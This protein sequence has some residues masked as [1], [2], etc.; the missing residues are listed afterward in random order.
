M[1]GTEKCVRVNISYQ[2][3]GAASL[4]LVSVALMTYA[5]LQPMAHQARGWAI[6]IAGAAAAWT[7]IIG[8]RSVVWTVA[9]TVLRK[10]GRMLE[11]RAPVVAAAA[12]EEEIGR[13]HV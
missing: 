2:A 9:D 13:A 6:I 12:G 8:V 11:Q 7:T 10:F 5:T 4:W 1:T 3:V